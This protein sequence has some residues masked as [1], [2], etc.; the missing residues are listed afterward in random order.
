MGPD[1]TSDDDSQEESRDDTCNTVQDDHRCRLLAIDRSIHPF[2]ARTS[3]RTV[4]GIP[5][6]PGIGW[7]I[8]H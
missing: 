8:G 7:D 3:V 2:L 5:G 4:T 6:I 1:G